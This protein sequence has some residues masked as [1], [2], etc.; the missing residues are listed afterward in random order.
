MTNKGQNKIGLDLDIPKTIGVFGYMGS[1]KSYFLGTVTESSVNHF[2]NIKNFTNIGSGNEKPLSVII[3]NYRRNC[4]D[5]FELNSFKSKNDDQ[6]AT[7]TLTN[8]LKHPQII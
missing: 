7:Q 6:K 8:L 5:R 4:L 1:E 2:K 3:F